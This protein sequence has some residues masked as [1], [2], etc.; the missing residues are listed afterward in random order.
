MHYTSQGCEHVAV[1]A[2]L[3]H[4]VACMER[5]ACAIGTK[6]QRIAV[7]P[8]HQV[9]NMVDMQECAGQQVTMRCPTGQHT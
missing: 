7:Q 4:S 5:Q 3:P 9:T 8:E 6:D 1:P 2:H